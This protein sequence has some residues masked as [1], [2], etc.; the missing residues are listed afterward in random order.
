MEYREDT[1]DCTLE[2]EWIEIVRRD[3]PARARNA[4]PCAMFP[5]HVFPYMLGRRWG[6]DS[7]CTTDPSK[8]KPA[9]RLNPITVSH[10]APKADGQDHLVRA[11][12][13]IMLDRASGAREFHTVL[14]S[15]G[16]WD[17]IA[18]AVHANE[19][20]ILEGCTIRFD[21]NDENVVVDTITHYD[22][23][24]G[25]G[26]STG[27]YKR[28]IPGEI[29]DVTSIRIAHELK[30]AESAGNSSDT[31]ANP[32]CLCLWTFDE[33]YERKYPPYEPENDYYDD[34]IPSLSDS[35]DDLEELELNTR[36]DGFD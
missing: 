15:K 29:T 13:S 27:T 1:P 5:N 22:F 16:Q 25:P 12:A 19:K 18:N 10:N 4:T 8:M 9:A 31:N 33:L 2:L 24:E 17:R 14:F 35:Y 32:D 21:P 36:G 28:Y 30:M 20:V 6:D 23:A 26:F 7:G 3:Q 34:D 11:F